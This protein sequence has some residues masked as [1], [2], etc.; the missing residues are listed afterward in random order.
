MKKYINS[1]TNVSIMPTETIPT[2]FPENDVENMDTLI[3]RGDFISR[4][5]L[6]RHAAREIIK[7]NIEKKTYGDILVK[8]MKDAGDFKRI[9]WKTLSRIL[10]NPKV[11][12]GML[13]Q[14]ERKAVRKL[15]RDPMGLLKRDGDRFTLT[16]NGESIARGYIKGLLHSRML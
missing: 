13:N 11:K 10:I 4:S 8:K 5:D 16:K 3:G 12:E 9:E 6:I 2:K 14:G 15:L 7:R 1:I